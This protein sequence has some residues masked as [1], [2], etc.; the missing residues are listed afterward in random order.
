LE[1]VNPSLPRD[2]FPESVR[3]ARAA[4]DADP[5]AVVVGSSRGGAVAMAIQPTAAGLV[6][7]APAWR[8]FGVSPKL[9]ME[10]IILHSSGDEVIP[11]EDSRELLRQSSLPD[12][13]L[14]V[15][16]ENH[17]MN[18]PEALAALLSAVREA[19]KDDRR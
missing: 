13:C 7:I 3:I 17:T 11:I 1:V 2:D 18:D 4:F 12:S 5:P 15:V 8:H 16:G 19:V 9:S 14:R 6:L 10:P